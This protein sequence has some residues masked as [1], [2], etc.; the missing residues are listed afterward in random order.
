MVMWAGGASQPPPWQSLRGP[1]FAA[2]GAD[3]G[4]VAGTP[5]LGD[6]GLPVC[7]VLAPGENAKQSKMA[8]IARFFNTMAP[9]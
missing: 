7:A 1:G 6:G 2:G 4:E 5:A 9:M 8:A 3:A